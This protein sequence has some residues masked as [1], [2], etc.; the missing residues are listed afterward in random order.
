MLDWCTS[1]AAKLADAYTVAVNDVVYGDWF[2][3]S[4][5][6]LRQMYVNKTEISGFVSGDYWSSTEYDASQAGTIDAA[7]GDLDHELKSSTTFK[8]RPVRAF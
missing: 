2:L 5:G 1:G 7:A 8:V 3:P 4:V 6:E